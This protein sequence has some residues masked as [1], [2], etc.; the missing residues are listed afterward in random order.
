MIAK[1]K[2][3]TF[4]GVFVPSTLTIFGVIMY[5]R[6]G[7]VVGSL[8]F[9]G[10]IIVITIASLITFIT[11]M[12]IASIATNT[13]VGGGGAYYMISR[14]LGVE[15]GAAVGIPLFFAQ[16]IG[17]TFY[18]MGF[19]EALSWFVPINTIIL[20]VATLGFIALVVLK[21]TNF[22]LKIQYIIFA[23]IV[24]SL[25]SFFWGVSSKIPVSVHAYTEI[26]KLSFWTVFAVF[27][28]AVTGIEAGLSM[29]GSLQ[30]PEKSLPIGTLSAVCCGYIVYVLIAYYFYNY[31]DQKSLQEE[32]FIFSKV[33]KIP[34]VVILG[35]WGACLSS[36]IGGMLGAPRTL[37]AL[38]RDR[39]VPKWL[40]S[41]QKDYSRL[42]LLFTIFIALLGFI[43][44]DLNK[45]APVLSMF[46]LISYGMINLSAAFEGFIAS[47]SWR[48]KFNTPWFVSLIGFFS[49]F[50][51]MF[52]I[53]P[54]ATLCSIL[55]ILLIYYL[56]EKRQLNSYWGDMRRGIFMLLAKY[57]IEKLEILSQSEKSWRPNILVFSGVPSKRWHLIEVASA[58]TN[59][60]GFLTI[61]YVV[62]PSSSKHHDHATG[63]SSVTDF[64]SKN[65]V[66]ALVKEIVSQNIFSG[67]FTF[68][69]SYG[70]GTIYPNTIVM[71]ANQDKEKLND[72]IEFLIKM[73]KI[74]RNVVIIKKN[75]KSSLGFKRGRLLAS[76]SNKYGKGRYSI[77][78]WWGR[79]KRNAGLS[80]ALSF[81]IQN[82]KEW[83]NT[84]LHLKSLVNDPNDLESAKD[85]INYM[86]KEARIEAHGAV[87]LEDHSK[88]EN[89]FSRITKESQNDD[90]VFLGIL[91]PDLEN[92]KK[93]AKAEIQRYKAYYLEFTNYLQQIPLLGIVMASEEVDFHKIFTKKS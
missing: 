5:L 71:G 85:T 46:F 70:L 84:S 54:G 61:A 86:I 58:I 63:I 32:A 9:I 83:A 25:I 37:S 15:A 80:L 75:A 56:M 53:S 33:S 89:L 82:N 12:S 42:A 30:K 26:E 92:Y 59:D 11:A 73:Y 49:C 67:M 20:G 4:K 93:D 91:P 90:I 10:S 24:L 87:Y 74:R 35:V 14:S 69:R 13:E 6:L 68:I 16:A 27:F 51:V 1:E 77:S 66:R 8:G 81:L 3:S 76:K 57:T 79:Q 7:W 34:S 72:Y 17:I 22:A 19:V 40:A 23:L 2:F 21:S 48:P 44:S 62:K 31:V 39:V 88:K 78:I 64:I 18:I 52:M 55:F 65:H 50:S 47:P 28:P 38:A 43:Y 45:I 36:A 60:K 29:S 41:E